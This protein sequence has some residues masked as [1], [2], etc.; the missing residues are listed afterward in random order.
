MTILNFYEKPVT[1]D[2]QQHRQLRLKKSPNGFAFAASTIAIP[3]AII[4]FPQASLEYPIVFAVGEKGPG[5]PIALTGIREKENLFIDAKG[6]W[7]GTYIPAFVRRYPFIL[8]IEPVT[9]TS[10]VLVDV[11]F[12]GLSSTEGERL[13]EEDG[14]ETAITKSM[15]EFLGDF[16]T[17][18]E[19]S[20][21]FMARLKKF[22][23]LI[24]QSVTVNRGDTPSLTLDGFHIVDEKK[25]AELDD[26][27]TLELAR[28]GDLARIHTHLLSLNNIQKVFQRLNEKTGMIPAAAAA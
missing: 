11:A 20:N 23:L 27:A 22:D 4:E 12:D 2:R 26:A 25:L 3:L 28:S 18:G 15:L 24:P 1:L 10:T 19:R 7:Q 14:T 9:N 5:T 21:E 13:F 6:Q 8:N 16:K 17:Q